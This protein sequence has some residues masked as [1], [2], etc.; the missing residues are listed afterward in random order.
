VKTG[1]FFICVAAAL[2]TAGCSAEKHAAA[3]Q[4]AACPAGWKAGWQKLANEIKAPVY[5]PTWMPSPLTGQIGGPWANGVSLDK[6]TRSYLASFLYHESNTGDVH[7]NFRGYPGQTAI[8]RCVE[9][10]L[11]GGKTRRATVPC[12]AD[13]HGHRHAQ[14]LDATVY[15]V[16]QDADQ[17]HVLY[18]WRRGGSL[19]TV[20]EHVA[21]PLTYGKVVRNLDRILR[22]LALVRPTGS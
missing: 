22:G 17:W 14:G 20:S 1:V 6:R 19:Y 11:G 13:P 12:F 21:R 7:V 9:L 8:P 18:A 15:T 4:A 5:C 16:N 10:K 2:A 3:S